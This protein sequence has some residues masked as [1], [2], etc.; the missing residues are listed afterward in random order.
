MARHVPGMRLDVKNPY[1]SKE[2]RKEREAEARKNRKIKWAIG[3][4]G[5][6]VVLL[7]VLYFTVFTGSGTSSSQYLATDHLKLV[8]KQIQD[9]AAALADPATPAADKAKLQ[10]DLKDLEKHRDELKMQSGK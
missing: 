9:C 6:L 2:K 10:K 3:G 1:E 5:A 7:A 4:G 8:E